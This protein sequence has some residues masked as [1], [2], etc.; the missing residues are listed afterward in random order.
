MA[1]AALKSGIEIEYDEFGSKEHP[2]LLL[3]MG[4]GTQMTAWREEWCQ[5][6]ADHGFRVIRYDNRDVG[7]SS[8][9]DHLGVPSIV[10]LFKAHFFGLHSSAPY[11]LKDMAVD[12]VELLD[13]LKIEKAHVCGISM[14]GM[15]VQEIAIH[16]PERLLSLTSMMSTTGNRK[17]PKPPRKIEWLMVMKPKATEQNFEKTVDH[18]VRIMKAIGSVKGL[19]PDEDKLYHYAR[20]SKLRSNRQAGPARQM[21]AIL[22]SPP[23]TEALQ[24]IKTPSLVIHGKA[25]RLVHP[26]AGKETARCIPGARLELIE[27]MGHDMPESLYESLTSLIAEFAFSSSQAAA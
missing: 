21:F 23:R 8:Q 25:D 15:I 11:L 27:D 14:G 3:V 7:L 17:L 12:A 22:C 20:E 9:L 13:A 6:L 4:L 26:D 19:S 18:S 2:T 5:M 10:Q 1:K 16:F 24:T